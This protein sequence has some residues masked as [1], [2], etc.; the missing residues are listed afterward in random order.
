MRTLIIGL[1]AYD[2]GTFERL[3]ENGKMPN[4]GAFVQAGQYAHF[5]V[6]NPPQSEVSWTSIATGLNPGGHGMFDF[7]HRD[8]ASYSQFVSLLPT[9]RSLGGTQF[10]SPFTARTIF[11]Q[12]VRKGFPATALWWPAMFPARLESPVGT[13]P[14]LGTPDLLGKLGVGTL[15]TTDSSQASRQL[16]TRVEILAAAGKG[17]LAGVVRGPS[18]QKGSASQ[19]ITLELGLELV[20]DR[21]ARLAL[22]KQPI[23]LKLGEWSPILEL[24][25]KVGLFFKLHALT[26]VILT[27][28]RPDVRLYMLPLQIHPLHSPWPYATPQSLVK[29]VWQAGGPFL[30]I[31]W[32]Q[33]TTG[34]EEGC[35]SDDQFLTL[36]ETIVARREQA[37]MSQ[38]GAFKEGL[39][40]SVFD[41]LD[42]IQHM[43]LRDRPDV[44]DDWYIRFDRLVGRA[45]QELNRQ[46]TN[47]HVVVVSDHGF[48]RFDYKVHL[49]RWLMDQGYLVGKIAGDRGGFDQVDWGRTRA[50]AIGLNSIYLN[51]SGR[52]G[53]GIVRPEEVEGLV[54][55][56]HAGLASWKGPDG[57]N[58]VQRAYSR[59]EALDGPLTAYGPDLLVGYAPG[60][61]AS[62]QT[63]LGAWEKD[64]LEPNRDH[65]GADHCIDPQSV[66]G[67]L[68]SNRG[69]KD[70]PRPSYRDIPAL[71][72]GEKP[73]AGSAA[74]P[75]TTGGNAEDQKA[76]EER[77]KSLGYL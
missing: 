33:D 19:E 38:L 73:E 12:T 28:A 13:I 77:L 65:W 48:S 45:L 52:E 57:R 8:P 36:C 63:G 21:S 24:T 18:Q 69:M 55:A 58:I 39:L 10:A 49:N 20:D 53:Q 23:E 50:Y 56:I 4:L 44:I 17:R 1:D 15:F 32:P 67:V 62:S 75:P 16:K 11:D 27:H 2:P 71:I 59:A 64:S 25:F 41:S 76:V 35:M 31:G 60:Y 66:P 51:Y 68:F 29:G 30:T 3:L 47:S 37:L 72:T 43:F 40:A 61:R 5:E 26:R 34:L 14:G 42:R 9:R 54:S 6:S 70:L 22:G 74:P 46:A 7:V